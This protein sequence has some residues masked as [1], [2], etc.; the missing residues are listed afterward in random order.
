MFDKTNLLPRT[1]LEQKL[2]PFE[3]TNLIK[4]LSLDPL[5]ADYRGIRHFRLRDFLRDGIPG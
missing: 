1:R 2:G 4:V 5:V 3:G